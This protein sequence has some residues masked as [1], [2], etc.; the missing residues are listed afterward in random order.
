[1]E[2]L[3]SV[4]SATKIIISHL[5]IL[6]LLLNVGSRE[7]GSAPQ[8]PRLDVTSILFHFLYENRTA[9]WCH[10]GKATAG[11]LAVGF[12]DL[13]TSWVP[14]VEHLRSSIFKLSECVGSSTATSKHLSDRKS[15]F[16]GLFRTFSYAFKLQSGISPST[17]LVSLYFLRH[18]VPLFV[19]VP[20]TPNVIF[21]L[22]RL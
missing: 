12:R 13:P 9:T 6:S 21:R 17:D 2:V 22:R 3:T 16:F 15:D 5:E 18:C 8:T 7:G 14:R 4:S 19:P 10:C 1:M 11:S 20:T